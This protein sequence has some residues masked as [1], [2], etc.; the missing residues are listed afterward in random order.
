[1]GLGIFFLSIFTIICIV[2]A[3]AILVEFVTAVI[4]LVLGIVYRKKDKQKS[5]ALFVMSAYTL[6]MLIITV[7]AGYFSFIKEINK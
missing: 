7:A 4:G 6:V 1:M 5:I 3:L 2:V